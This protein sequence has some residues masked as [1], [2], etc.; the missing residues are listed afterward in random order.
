M[1]EVGA[2]QDEGQG[3]QGPWG[4]GKGTVPAEF[5]ARV[6]RSIFIYSTHIHEAPS[7]CQVR[8]LVDT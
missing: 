1:S 8:G 6:T 5:E 2:A 3:E 7:R 4:T